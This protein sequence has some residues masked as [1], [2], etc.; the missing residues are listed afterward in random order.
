MS[1]SFRTPFSI[2]KEVQKMAEREF[3]PEEI[4]R[5]A[6]DAWQGGFGDFMFRD[7]G[8]DLGTS[9]RRTSR[10]RTSRRRTSRRRTS[11]RGMTSR[12]QTS[13]RSQTSRRN[14]SRRHTSR[15]RTSRRRTSRCRTSRR[16][17]TSRKRLCCTGW[18]NTARGNHQTMSCWRDGNMWE[19]RIRNR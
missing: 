2:S 13:R 18:R 17:H 19:F 12:R 3:S 5:A 7:P 6:D 8:R 14:T 16:R 4:Q 10:R 15:R 1:N 9:R 11:R